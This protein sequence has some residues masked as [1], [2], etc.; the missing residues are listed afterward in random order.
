MAKS[1]KLLTF[2][3]DSLP[4]WGVS[5]GISTAVPITVSGTE[6]K[7]TRDVSEAMHNLL[8][9]RRD[10]AAV[11]QVRRVISDSRSRNILDATVFQLNGRKNKA[12]VS[13]KAKKRR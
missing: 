2:A 5:P 3:D 13:A 7:S 12:K 9:S 8:L 6:I 11:N 10:V 4:E 1:S